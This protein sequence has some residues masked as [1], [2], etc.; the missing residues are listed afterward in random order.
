MSFT[1][2]SSRANRTVRVH[3]SGCV[4]LERA[5]WPGSHY[6]APKYEDAPDYD[7]AMTLANERAANVGTQRI[8]ACKL[9][10]PFSN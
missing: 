6:G 5:N 2:Y 9:C 7:A 3:R 1:V 10:L 4:A 8:K